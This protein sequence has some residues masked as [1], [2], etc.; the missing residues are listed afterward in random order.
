MGQF[1]KLILRDRNHPSVILWS[2]GNEEWVIHGTETGHNIANSLISRLK[3]LDPTRLY[4]YAG[5]NGNEFAGIN[6][7]MPIR[8]FNYMNNNAD[9]DKYH[10]DHPGQIL[11]GSEEA[12]TLCTRG[13]YFK[14]SVKGYVPDYDVTFPYWGATA[15]HWLKYYSARDFLLGA[16][17]WTGFDYRGEPTPYEWPCINS[18]FGI[19]DVCGFPKNNYY[20]YQ[21]WWSNKD[22]LHICPHWNWKGKEGEIIDVWCNSNCQTVELFLNGKSLGRKTMDPFSH[23]EWKVPYKPG[24]LEARGIRDGRKLT[25]RI[26]TTGPPASIILNPD[27]NSINGDGEDVSVINVSVADE[28]GREVA[29]AGNLITF[30]LKGNGRIIGVGNGDPSSHE[31]DKCLAGKYQRRLFNGKCQLIVQSGTGAGTI[32]VIASTA[33]LKPGSALIQAGT[34]TPRPGVESIK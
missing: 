14:D 16:F 29:D 18:H 33:G 4:S 2:I 12:S 5:N 10:K 26:E 27:R 30:E 7:L 11:M 22:V 28:K 34:C 17:V 20:Y 13:I 15:E 25:E 32:E 31:A 1:E 9:I 8:G 3:E 6:E 19:M 21:S 23:L 24:V